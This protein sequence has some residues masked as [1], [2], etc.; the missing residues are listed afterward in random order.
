MAKKSLGRIGFVGAGR[1][2]TGLMQSLLNA[3]AVRKSDL[4]ASDVQADARRR[5]T[6]AI[7]VKTTA[8]NNAVLRFAP[9]VVLAVKP[10]V[11][12]D[13][14]ASIKPCVTRD[15][16]L[17][18]IAAGV[19]IE[20]LEDALG[21]GVRVARVMPNVHCVVGEAASAYCM[22]SRARA[23]DA[24]T[25]EALLG[26]AGRCMPVDET[27]MDAVT[28]LS[29]SGPAFVA[30]VIGALADGG[31][32]VGLAREVATLLAAQTVLGAG[33]MILEAGLT[34]EQLKDM[35]PSPGGTT[36]AGIHVLERGGLRAALMAAVEAATRRSEELGRPS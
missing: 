21:A 24:R 8:D 22:G 28:G 16:L 6:Q 5:L 30:L 32:K 17:V 26:A 3:G 2:A 14:L 12:D 36:I 10:Q 19:R 1:M 25:V 7:G 27:L 15:H 4:M 31:V 13:V 29:G 20:R 33:K 35:V 23:A 11:I 18:S 34:P 9:T